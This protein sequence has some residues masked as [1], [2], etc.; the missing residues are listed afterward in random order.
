MSNL[1][2]INPLFEKIITDFFNEGY[3]V[4]DNWLS[5]SEASLLTAE[6]AQLHQ[7]DCFRKSAI[8]NKLNETVKR[9]IRSDFIYWLDE[10]KHAQSFFQK[11]NSFIEYI[12]KN[13]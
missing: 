5:K 2:P 1:L 9:S 6:L 13:K 8:G 7:E 12:N 10:T 3:C 4:I 11:V